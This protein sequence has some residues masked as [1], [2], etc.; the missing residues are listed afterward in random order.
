MAAQPTVIEGDAQWVIEL[1][2]KIS[3][4]E[5]PVFAKLKDFV[6]EVNAFFWGV[7]LK[8]GRNAS[9]EFD[10]KKPQYCLIKSMQGTSTRVI[11]KHMMLS[12]VQ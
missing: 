7:F 8:P 9:G 10:G 6:N 3:Y 12:T 4:G 2:G 5:R 1:G 11:K